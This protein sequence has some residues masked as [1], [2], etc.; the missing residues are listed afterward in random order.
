VWKPEHRRAAAGTNPCREAAKGGERS[1]MVREWEGRAQPRWQP[2]CAWARKKGIL[3]RC[4]G[5]RRGQEDRGSQK[6]IPGTRWFILPMFKTVTVH[7][8]FSTER[9]DCPIHW[10]ACNLPM[11]VRQTEAS[12][13][14]KNTAIKL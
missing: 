1:V 14:D 12:F 11:L 6:H 9:E 8:T 10:T 3:A 5:L 4:F 7:P 2:S 13:G